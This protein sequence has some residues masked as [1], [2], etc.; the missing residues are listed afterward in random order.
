[1]I[2]CEYVEQILFKKLALNRMQS[3]FTICHS[4]VFL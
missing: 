4:S 2:A 1:M 3:L